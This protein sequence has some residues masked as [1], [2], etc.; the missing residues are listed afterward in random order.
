MYPAAEFL[1]Y[2]P[3]AEIPVDTTDPVIVMAP[4]ATLTVQLHST[5]QDPG[6]YAVDNS[7]AGV[8]LTTSGVAALN[9]ALA[10]RNMR[11]LGAP[12]ATAGTQAQLYGPWVIVYQAVD[13]AGN[14]AEPALRKVLIDAA[15]PGGEKRCADTAL[16]PVSGLCLPAGFSGSAAYAP[17]PAP[18][19]PPVDTKAP[20]VTPVARDSDVV[21]VASG[22]AAVPLVDTVVTAGTAYSDSGATAVDN[23]DGNLT[24]KVAS[25]GKRDVRTDAPTAPLQPYIIIYRV[26]DA[27]GN[28]GEAVRRV[29]VRC[30]A[31]ERICNSTAQVSASCSTG[32]VCVA[33][34]PAPLPPPVQPPRMWLLG[35]QTLYIEAGAVYAKCPSPRPLAIVCDLVRPP[36]A[37]MAWHVN[38][39]GHVCA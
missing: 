31:A 2:E 39:R 19:V 32:G 36:P 6:A 11:A 33:A 22:G 5:F 13:A 10:S 23:V 26:S 14:R 35:Q 18:Y 27:A 25:L 17:A 4:P 38:E 16:C 20:V 34:L 15:C 3:V 21:V 24:A 1:D 12:V 9:T 30:A 29:H 7:A 37:G 8:T 28:V